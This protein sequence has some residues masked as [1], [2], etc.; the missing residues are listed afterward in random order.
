M[1][2]NLTDAI[3]SRAEQQPHAVAVIDPGRIVDYRTF[4]RAI[5]LAARRFRQAGWK[6]GDTVGICLRE[7]PTLF[8]V[9]SFALARMGA[10]QTTLSA[11]DA[12]VLRR[13]RIELLGVTGLVADDGAAAGGAGTVTV[14]P[15]PGWLSSPGPA[16]VED[17]REPGGGRLCFVRETSGTTAAPK[18]LGI[19]HDQEDVHRRSVAGIF[20][21]LPGERFLNFGGMRFFTALRRAISCL[22][23]GGTLTLPPAGLA[24]DQM[25]HWI[26]FH[27]VSHIFCV[28]VHLHQLL[29]D[30]GTTSPRLP[31]LRILH[32][33][34][35]VLTASAVHE[36]RKRISPNL[37]ISYGFS[38]AGP[39]VAATPAMLEDHPDCL[40]T[41][42][43]GVELE[44]VD[45]EDRPVAD[46][47]PGHV[48]VRGPGVVTS[49]LGAVGPDQART[50]RGG[51]FY[52]GDV[53]LRNS[54]ALIFHKGRSDEVMNFD[55]IL[56]GPN[57][58]E[59][60]LRQHPA[61]TDVA[62]FA[63]PS[64]EHQDIPAAAIVSSQ[65]VNADELGRFCTERLGIRSPRIFVQIDAIPRNAMG[66]I[67]RSRLAESAIQRLREQGWSW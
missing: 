46:G 60:V 33:G 56:V 13:A 29:R 52:P 39:V 31:S 54:A 58:I 42:L 41:L 32:T 61:V 16:A 66:K 23:D 49:Y 67:L 18:V 36:V 17:I 22:S 15:D 27:H 10:V 5:S 6:A 26:D 7:D 65:A 11:S 35:A 47:V 37:Y 9:S 3:F 40:G 20:P 63:L 34:T 44:L 25:L 28:P 57:E 24:T 8:L 50:F 62:A 48:R 12:A 53:A 2:L 51:W 64:L 14:A 21:H 45:D 59:S 19:T 1:S 38:E 55:G 30:I 43:P 4:S